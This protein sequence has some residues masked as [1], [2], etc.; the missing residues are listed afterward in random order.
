MA[1]LF[2]YVQSANSNYKK[3]F[4]LDDTNIISDWSGKRLR[5]CTV[6]IVRYTAA[7]ANIYL[8]G[9]ISGSP[10]TPVGYILSCIN[11]GIMVS[12]LVGNDAMQFALESKINTKNA[13]PVTRDLNSLDNGI[14]T[15]KA[16]STNTPVSGKGGSILVMANNWGSNGIQ[17]ASANGYMGFYYRNYISD[18]S[19]WSTWRHVDVS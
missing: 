16:D 12:E 4:Y 1:G 9:S 18:E 8:Y 10:W 5:Y 13:N 14:M 2:T 17:I 15:Y 7:V 6:S 3:W 11:G 19:R